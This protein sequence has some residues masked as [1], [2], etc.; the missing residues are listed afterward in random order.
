MRRLTTRSF[1][2]RNPDFENRVREN[3]HR[4]TAMKTFGITIGKIE[5]GLVEL[6]MPFN[7]VFTQQHGF[8]HAGII[9]TGIDTACGYAAFTL[10]E[11]G[12]EV[13]TVEFK[14]NFVAPATGEK[15]RFCGEVLKQGKTITVTEGKVYA[16]SQGTEK[17]V[18]SMSATMM[19]VRG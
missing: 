14:T 6:E 13:L 7:P 11:E 17:L 16:V 1:E 15:F 2:P 12:A 18:A 10:M 19:A 8:M 3:F 5:S 4:Q 9:T